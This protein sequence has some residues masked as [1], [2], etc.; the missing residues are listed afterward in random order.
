MGWEN[1]GWGN[2]HWNLGWI[3]RSHSDHYEMFTSRYCSFSLLIDR[4]DGSSVRLQKRRWLISVFARDKMNCRAFLSINL[5]RAG[6]SSLKASLSTSRFNFVS[7]AECECGN[8]LQ[9]EE[10]IFC[11]RTKGKG[12]GKGKHFVW[13]QQKRILIVSYRALKARG[14]VFVQGVYYFAN[15]IPNFLK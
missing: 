7:T 8:G 13:E 6:H 12:K 5:L 14:K 4:E 15:K 1:V 10:H 11:T 9:T 2:A 3:W